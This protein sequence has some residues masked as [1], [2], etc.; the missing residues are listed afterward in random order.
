M[1]IRAI[2]FFSGI[3]IIML[4]SC[5]DVSYLSGYR[6]ETVICRK[7][8][9]AGVIN[10]IGG[11]LN[12]PSFTLLANGTIIYFDYVGG[13][14]S[15]V[16]GQLTKKEFF[17]LFTRIQKIRT[18]DTK[19]TLRQ[20]SDENILPVVTL[21][22]PDG[23]VRF[24]M[25]EQADTITSESRLTLFSRQLDSVRIKNSR[26]YVAD[27]VVL[28]ARPVSSGDINLLPSWPLES[29]G[30]DTLVK[31]QVSMYEPNAVE[32]SV[33]LRKPM[34]VR[35]QKLIPQSGIYKKFAYKNR[36]YAVGYRPLI[37]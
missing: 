12:A 31:K 3:L 21:E 23:A 19:D 27:S 30:L 7:Q 32:N 17:L 5:A 8:I 4:S 18:D 22:F 20:T 9:T 16:R 28:F 10:R 36:I 29:V 25:T 6:P 14:R 37:P 13:Q 11:E 15:L 26:L 35:I 2:L 34:S 1:T 24:A 33:M